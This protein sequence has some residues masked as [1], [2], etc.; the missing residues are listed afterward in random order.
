VTS[1]A[2]PGVLALAFLPRRSL[3]RGQRRSGRTS[4]LIDNAFASLGPG[5]SVRECGARGVWGSS[6]GVPKVDRFALQLHAAAW[7]APPAAFRVP[8]ASHGDGDDT[9]IIIATIATLKPGGVFRGSLPGSQRSGLVLAVVIPHG[10]L[11]APRTEN[12][13]LPAPSSIAW[14]LGRNRAVGLVGIAQQLAK[15]RVTS[16]APPLAQLGVRACALFGF[17]LAL[18]FVMTRAMPVAA[19][20]IVGPKRRRHRWK[21]SL[22]ALGLR[23]LTSNS[24]LTCPSMANLSLCWP[25]VP[26]TAPPGDGQNDRG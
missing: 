10:T 3:K 22:A 1:P 15:G 14:L 19:D 23:Q 7:W 16:K 20:E 9:A 17:V 5:E 13:R 8:R 4:A 12:D 21:S 24:P 18:T 2:S 6:R 25:S 11:V 26:V